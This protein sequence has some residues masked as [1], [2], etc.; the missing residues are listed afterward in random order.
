MKYTLSVCLVIFLSANLWW[1]CKNSDSDVSPTLTRQDSLIGNYAGVCIEME[2]SLNFETIQYDTLRDTFPS[3][4]K[5]VDVLFVNNYNFSINTEGFLFNRYARD[6]CSFLEDTVFVRKS[7]FFV[8]EE[9]AIVP[10]EELVIRNLE[11]LFTGDGMRTYTY[12]TYLK[13]E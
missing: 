5:V 10:K 1:G 9:L 3:E 6:D 12:C 8:T 4:M 7:E 2:V 11:N 13:V